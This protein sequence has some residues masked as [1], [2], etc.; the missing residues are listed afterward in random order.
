MKFYAHPSEQGSS[1]SMPLER[2]PTSLCCSFIICKV[3]LIIAA[4]LHSRSGSC[5]ESEIPYILLSGPLLA[6]V[7]VTITAM[8]QELSI[9]L[10]A[11]YLGQG[12]P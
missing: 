4:T 5:V 11:M 7:C 8:G 9:F 10:I 3:E 2:N 6:K 12:H 1:R